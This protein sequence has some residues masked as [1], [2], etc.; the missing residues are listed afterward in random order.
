MED[1]WGESKPN[2]ADSIRPWHISR[3][4]VCSRSPWRVRVRACLRSFPHLGD[5]QQS[6][7][8]PLFDELQEIGISGV[9]RVASASERNWIV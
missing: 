6:L 4:A 7:L 8:P 3:F 2:D 5:H 1:R 9:R